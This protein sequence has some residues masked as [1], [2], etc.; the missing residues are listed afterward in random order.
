M[1]IRYYLCVLCLTVINT[2]NAKQADLDDN[3]ILVVTE[4]WPPFNYVNQDNQVVGIA[5]EILKE[6]LN[7]A[8]LNYQISVYGWQRAYN[9]AK[10][11]K[12]T[13]IYTIFRIDS[14]EDDFQW[15]CPLI[16][17]QGV[18]VYRLKSRE[19]INIKHINDLKSYHLGVVGTGVTYDYLIA[20]GFSINRNIDIATD[21]LANIRKLFKGRVDLIIQ[22][23]EPLALRMQQVGLPIEGLKKVFAILSN[24]ERQAC[25]AMSLDTSKAVIQKLQNALNKVQNIEEAK[26]NNHNN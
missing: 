13:L 5:T 11:N 2:T 22:E 10:N 3:N 1:N 9:L 19:D 21:E 7:E 16:S 6:V 23:E 20:H 14:R 8:N 17:T 4:P 18:S 24:K 15:I 26:L 12:N 25:M